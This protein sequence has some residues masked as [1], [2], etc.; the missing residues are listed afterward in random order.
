MHDVFVF[1]KSEQTICQ[2]KFDLPFLGLQGV[3]K[4]SVPTIKFTS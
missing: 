3:R 4:K 2:V 1:P